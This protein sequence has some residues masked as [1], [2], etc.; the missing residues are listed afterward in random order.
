VSE[1]VAVRLRGQWGAAPFPRCK[2]AD[3]YF[4]LSALLVVRQNLVFGIQYTPPGSARSVVYLG[5]IGPARVSRA[6]SGRRV[7]TSAPHGQIHFTT[8]SDRH[9]ILNLSRDSVTFTK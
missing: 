9:G 1:Q 4:D 5:N 3:H 2:D 6:P 7:E 8:T